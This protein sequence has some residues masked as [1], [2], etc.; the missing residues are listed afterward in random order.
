LV[1]DFKQRV[2]VK[3]LKKRVSNINNVLRISIWISLGISSALVLFCA[4]AYITSSQLFHVKN[5]TIRGC[6]QIQEDEI[7]S[8]LDIEKGDNILSCNIEAARQR[9]MEHSWVKDVSIT[10]RFI[11]TALVI[12][13]KEHLPIAAVFINGKGY[14]I[15][16]DGKIFASMP[17]GYRGLTMQTAGFVPSGVEMNVIIKK[18]VEA[19]HTLQTKGMAVEGMLIEPGGRATY[20]LKNGISVAT[21][22]SL[23]PAKLDTALTIMREMKPVQGTTLDLSCEDKV[24]LSTL[25]IKGGAA[26]SGG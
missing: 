11:P 4:A 19:I 9:L 23:T 18:G 26:S 22:G 13:I 16:A 15:N 21:L 5:I 7:L 17:K 20:K 6:S 14:V 12:N 24:V 1:E 8:L 10:R 25:P 2:R 3:S